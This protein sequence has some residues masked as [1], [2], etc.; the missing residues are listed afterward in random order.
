[1]ASGGDEV[2]QSVYTVVPKSGITLDTGFFRENVIVL[3]FE[4]S[5][6]LREANR[7]YYH[8]QLNHCGSSLMSLTWL[9]Y[10]FG[11]QI[12]ACQQ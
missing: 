5:D 8:Q 4:M 10:R 1:M 3:S 11:P 2:E 9:R 6:D 12:L 7:Q